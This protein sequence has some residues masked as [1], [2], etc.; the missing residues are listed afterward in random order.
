MVE[1]VVVARI[2]T[3]RR[4]VLPKRDLR[5]EGLKPGMY[6]AFKILAGGSTLQ[7]AILKAAE[8]EGVER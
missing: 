4:V 5:L 8:A 1:G 6:I 7:E 3:N 2:G